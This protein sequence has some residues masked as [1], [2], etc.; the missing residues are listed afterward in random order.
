[1]FLSSN[2]FNDISSNNNL[3][4]VLDL[5]KRTLKFR[6]EV[7][8]DPREY[9]A[10]IEQASVGFNLKD[11]EKIFMFVLGLGE[12]AKTWK[13]SIDKI[14]IWNDLVEIFLNRFES[15]ASE[16]FWFE[17]FINERY[18]NASLF[19]FLD[20][21]FYLGRRAGIEA[22]S[23]IKHVLIKLP[24]KIKSLIHMEYGKGILMPRIY[25]ICKVYMRI[26][27]S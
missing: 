2:T 27:V 25:E 17:K 8:D 15:K 24:E 5:T 11:E 12:E 16:I 22:D 13:Y 26:W 1:M 20:K 18:G 7:K 10:L 19:S 4:T 21:L 3:A 14:Y 6:N 9:I 23:I